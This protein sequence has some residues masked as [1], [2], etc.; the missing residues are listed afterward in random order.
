M[1][2]D[3]IVSDKLHISLN[4]FQWDSK[5]RN[6]ISDYTSGPLFFFKDTCIE[7]RLSKEVCC[8]KTCRTGTDY[9]GLYISR[10]IRF[11]PHYIFIFI[12]TLLCT[13]SLYL[14]YLNRSF[15]VHSCTMVLTLMVTN[16][17]CDVRKSVRCINET[18]CFRHSALSCKCN[19]LRNRLMDRT[20]LYTWSY[21]TI[22]ERKRSTDFCTLSASILFTCDSLRIRNFLNKLSKFRNVDSLFFPR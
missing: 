10:F 17:T 15:I 1:E 16:P 4:C 14:S 6:D 12:K 19:I 13:Y 18:Q 21:I 9:S 8:G 11:F 3:S 20:S 5:F 7:S 2:L 22:E